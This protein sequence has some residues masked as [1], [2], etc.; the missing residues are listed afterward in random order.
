MGAAGNATFGYFIVRST[1]KV[2]GEAP[3]N[4]DHLQPK[5]TELVEVEIADE[6]AED[7]TQS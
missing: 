3:A 2:L 6:A 5:A 1:K 4:W 7:P